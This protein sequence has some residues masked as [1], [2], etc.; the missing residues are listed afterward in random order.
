MQLFKFLL[1]SFFLLLAACNTSKQNNQTPE[2][3]KYIYAHTSGTITSGSSIYIYLEETPDSKF[4]PGEILPPN[5]IK[6]HPKVSG[7][8]L[9]SSEK[10][11]KFIPDKPLQN[12]EEYQ[13]K[14]NL[15]KLMNAP[16]S[17]HEYTFK[18]KV[19]ELK[20]AF[21][22]GNLQ[23]TKNED[24]LS[25]KGILYSSDFIPSSVIENAVKVKWEGNPLSINWEHNAH[26]HTFY[27]NNIAKGPNNQQLNF[28]FDTQLI[29]KE[30]YSITI[31][32]KKQFAVLNISLHNKDAHA[33]QVDMSNEPDPNQDPNGLITIK[34]IKDIKYRISQNSI[35]CYFT[36]PEKT[37]ELEVTVH[38]GLRDKEGQTLNENYTQILSL[39]SDNPAVKFIGDGIIVPAEGKILIPF[40]A[41]ALKAVD[42]QIIKIFRQNMNFFLQENDLDGDNEIIRTARPVFQKKIE[43]NPDH[44]IID[45]DKWNDFTL[46]LSDLVQ[47]EKGVIYRIDIRF[48]KS[49]TTLDC[50]QSTNDSPNYYTTDWDNDRY[51]Y[52]SGYGND[53][54]WSERNNPCSNS[55]Y[56]NNHFI[57]KN[58]INTSLGII[59]KRGSNNR[60][61]VAVNDIVTAE[62]VS[63][64]TVS[65]YDFQNQRIDSV[66]TDKNGFAYLNT[67]TQAFIV[68]AQ[69]GN[70]KAWLK[71]A[72]GNTLSMSNFNV[73]GQDVQSGLK[74]FI[75]G[76]R[77]V[78]RP[79]DNI[80]LA[81]ILDN[82]ENVLP[83]GHPIVAE[84]IDPEGQISESRQSNISDCPIHSF[85]FSTSPE[86]PT[87]YWRAAVKVGGKTFSKTLRIETVKPNRFSINMQFP[88][89]KLI[90]KGA[91][92]TIDVNTR[93]LNG[94]AAPKRKA[95]TEVKLNAANYQFKAYPDY[96]FTNPSVDFSPY[97]ATLFDG[98]TDENGHF[99][100]NTAKIDLGNAPGILKAT[101][102][103]RLFE[104]GGDFS[105]S[106]YTTYYSPYNQYAGFR[107]PQSEDGWYPTN[108][109][110]SLQGVVI[111]P[112][113]KKVTKNT[114]IEV[115]IYKLDWSWWWDS[116]GNSIGNYIHRSYNRPV[117]EKQI[118]AKEGSFEVNFSIPE[119]GRY[120]IETIDP[121][122]DQAAG[123]VVYFGSWAELSGSESATMLTFSTDKETYRT[124]EKV[125]VKIP[126]SQGGV[127]IV[128][129]ENGTRFKDIRRMTTNKEFT[130]FEFEATPAMAPNVYIFVTLLQPQKDKDNDRPIRMYGVVNIN[131]EDPA[132]HLQPVIQLNKEL[133]PGQDFNISVSEKNHQD[134][135]YTLAIVDEGLLSLTS[136]RTPE[137][138]PA[139]YAREALGVKTW[140]FYNYIFGA[141]GGRLEKAFAVG[142]DE[143]LKPV[144][145]EQTN[146]FKPVVI[147]KGPFALKKGEKQTHT[148]QMPE[149][150]GEVRAMVVAA[151][152]NGQYGSAS[153]N[154]LVKRPLMLSV[155]LPRLFSP[156]DLID[157]PVTV[158]AMDK[159]IK[160]VNVQLQT[161]D[162]IEI[163][164]SSSKTVQF[165]G[166]GE[167]LVWFKIQIKETT[168]KTNL[169]FTATAGNEKATTSEEVE[170]R[171]PNPPITTVDARLSEPGSV[172][173]FSSDLQGANPVSVLEITSIPP[174]NLAQRLEELLTYPHGCAEQITSAAFPQLILPSLMELTAQQKEKTESHV[175][176]AIQRLRQYQ[177]SNGGFAYW[178]GEPY[179]S[180][181][182]STYI[183][184]FLITASNTGYSIPNNL[185]QQD[186]NH[187]KTTANNYQINSYYGEMEQAYRLYVLALAGKPDMAAMNRMK[188]RKLQNNTAQWLLASAY[189]LCKYPDIARNLIRNVSTEVAPYR[190]TGYTFGSSIRDKSIILQALINLNMQKEA[191]EMLKQIASALSS[192]EWMS[193]Q[194]TAFALIS[195][196]DYVKHYVGNLGELDVQLKIN[197]SKESVKINH[198]V[199]Q[200]QL[201]LEHGKNNVEIKNN[202][203]S[204][205]YVR[206][207][208]TVA[209][210]RM[211][212]KKK[213]EGLELKVDYFNSNGQAVSLDNLTQGT[214][215]TA[216]VSVTNTGM[217]GRYDNLALS[218]LLA[219]G[220]EIIN[221]R[222]TGNLSAFKEA[223]YVDIRDDRYYVYFNLNQNQTKTF[224]FRFNAAFAGEYLQPAIT[225]NAMYDHAIEAI[226]PGRKISIHQKP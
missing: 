93:W 202:S 222:L 42:V 179:S 21:D 211:V 18:F 94:A 142:G 67:S 163:I 135:Y 133:R 102:N 187:L 224:T 111:H 109:P 120:Y 41:V 106:S 51:Y 223:D 49:Y 171:I 63:G 186:L 104:E 208:N 59:A 112:D 5:L 96:T 64:C 65:L 61:F 137:P 198:T 35:I 28:Y 143:S 6:I 188:E 103:T 20:A 183:A 19:V 165:T 87:G 121:E 81:F 105:S 207:I 90:G 164:N 88:E 52:E 23:P 129:L 9:Y 95:V 34:G 158:F 182:V 70:D 172:T 154:A 131:I 46:N 86:A 8:L 30:E 192:D 60:Y 26:T 149:Y 7:Q 220:F 141:Y 161:D 38:E 66:Y 176:S 150:I 151:T 73:S 195:V 82:Q 11:L 170:I 134:M 169:K 56:T 45:L 168:G 162:K 194:T 215:L 147:Y 36:S 118:L 77:G 175:K 127:A 2:T 205:L 57:H 160:D 71:V 197:N 177:T 119:Y 174:L 125:H 15:E 124:G 136:F 29:P 115:R 213:M 153:K 98:T 47:L 74:G 4:K 204:T 221:D 24:T 32:K 85:R 84:L 54:N 68:Q 92:N 110:L 91:V 152:N 206:V 225:C 33:V 114:K 145:D 180:E 219:D 25:Y 199:Y 40:S 123:Q 200:R 146:R 43:L 3:N 62:P 189:A 83:D 116:E 113:G 13:V 128:S 209:P 155:A 72:D 55:Y 148:L 185:L 39:P 117:F 140:D 138:F 80:Y 108:R 100:F 27:I 12:G 226:W 218:F 1:I 130:D 78:W 31:P 17:E 203:Q 191:F 37:S 76:E 173:D 214:D 44:K 181:W 48:R 53:Y 216:K 139:F 196:A 212:E 167:K 159:S 69:K 144:Q 58:I 22:S 50:A 178:P 89:N 166:T 101:F 107:L 97:S 14:L 193:T 210:Y 184:H 79:G 75:Y 122:S 16:V 132:L 157:V 156:G 10:T 201:P 217:I 99:S 190:Q 126:S